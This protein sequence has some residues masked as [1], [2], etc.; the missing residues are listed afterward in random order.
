[1]IMIELSERKMN[2][3]EKNTIKIVQTNWAAQKNSFKAGWLNVKFN[4][5]SW[6]LSSISIAKFYSNIELNADDI[7]YDILINRLKLPYTSIVMSQNNFDSISEKFWITRK[8]YSYSLQKQPFIHIDGDAMLFQP[9]EESL[10]NASLIAQNYEYDHPYYLESFKEICETCKY[11]PKYIKKDNLGRISAANAGIIGGNNFHF[12]E[13]YKAEVDHF[14]CQNKKQLEKMETYKA[15]IFLEQ[16]LF[17]SLADEMDISISYQMKDKI[18]KINDYKLDRFWNLPNNCKYLHVMNYKQNPTICE[19]MAQR[20]Y[21]ENQELYERVIKVAIELEATKVFVDIGIEKTLIEK[22]FYRLSIITKSLGLQLPIIINEKD[23]LMQLSIWHSKLSETK[24]L[25]DVLQ[26]E[27]EKFKYINELPDENI[28]IEYRKRQSLVTNKV[29][30]L[31]DKEVL[32]QNITFSKYTGSIESEWKWAEKN[33]FTGQDITVNFIDNL[34]MGPSYFQVILFCYPVSITI[35]EQLLDTISILII[36][37]IQKVANN[38]LSIAE[39]IKNVVTEIISINPE[40]D[41]SILE[42][43][44]IDKVRY[45]L[46]QGVLCFVE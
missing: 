10:L 34:K 39:L 6:A 13:N 11:L 5:M 35:K 44:I 24:I 33:E 23:I 12:F 32:K 30:S 26:Y 43:S 15:N 29:L 1:M 31:P 25:T 37:E 38:S 9:F 20:L 3:I 22:F 27:I 41:S 16:Y 46:Y 19:Q 45:M 28:I 42:N 17:K 14:I 18:G 4:L 40:N 2:G 7:G 21:I 36:D 8:L